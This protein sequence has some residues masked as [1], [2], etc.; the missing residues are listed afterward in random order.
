MK[1][2]TRQLRGIIKEEKRKLVEQSRGLA[3][4]PSVLENNIAMAMQELFEDSVRS[5]SYEGTGPTWD[6]EIEAAA[7]DLNQA[8][9]DS[10]AA[11]MMIELFNTIEEDLHN[12][13]YV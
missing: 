2:S 9:I 5:E 8:I 11:K 7:E 4:N 1:I 13:K 10:G 6:E 12:G 3:E